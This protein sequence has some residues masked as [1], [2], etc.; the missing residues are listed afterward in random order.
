MNHHTPYQ[1]LETIFARIKKLEQISSMLDWDNATNLPAGSITARISHLSELKTLVH[2]IYLA[3]KT[4]DL[5]HEVATK[6][7][8]FQQLAN[9][10]LMQKRHLEATIIDSDLA[11]ALIKATAIS[12]MSWRAARKNNDFKSYAPLLQEVVNLVKQK[13]ACKSQKLGI[14]PYDALGDEY[15]PG[16]STA[17][18]DKIF[19]SLR[20]FLKSFIPEVLAHQQ[21]FQAAPLEKIHFSKEK[22]MLLA[23]EVMQMMGFDFTK[24]RIDL[25]E[26]PFC[27]GFS[28]D[29]RITTHFTEENFL[30]GLM[31]VIHESGHGLYEQNLPADWLFQPLGQATG[32]AMHESQSLFMEMQMCR[33]REF[34]NF[35]IPSICKFY[36]AEIKN[37]EPQNFYRLI[38]QVK[39]SLIRINA[40]EVTYPLHIILRYE[41]EKQM[42]SSSLLVKD[43]PNAFNQAMQQY[44]GVT[45]T[46]D[47]MGCLQDIHW[48]SGYFGYF[49]SYSLGAMMG[50]QFH[51]ALSHNT[52]NHMSNIAKGDFSVCVNYLNKNIHQMGSTYSS[53]QLV[54]KIT[55]KQLDV[56]I[57]EKYLRKRFITDYN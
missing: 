7:L 20:T 10:K 39:P 5:L 23:K 17:H 12:E 21:Q 44:L 29:C 8:N 25:S 32:M 15:E 13:A 46:N 41:L 34:V 37:L 45:P 55:G 48:P 2:E 22:Q 3:P 56:S 6:E 30:P 11:N 31:G 27:G 28:A 42:L 47:A 18:T 38:N 35:I 26:H 14:S 53:E 49:P 36:G 24:G 33:S 4:C 51:D 9:F 1:Q 52:P 54:Q 43:L 19:A 50:A 40:D 16:F 57:Y